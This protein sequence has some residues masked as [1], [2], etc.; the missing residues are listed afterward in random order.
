MSLFSL[1]S[2]QGFLD[3]GFLQCGNGALQGRCWMVWCFAKVTTSI[4]P[5]KV[6]AT[7]SNIYWGDFPLNFKHT[8]HLHTLKAVHCYA[9]LRFL[10]HI[11][12][13]W[14]ETKSWQLKEKR[15]IILHHIRWRL[16]VITFL[17]ILTHVL[18]N[19]LD[20]SLIVHVW[21]FDSLDMQTGCSKQ[22]ELL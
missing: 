13:H 7:H 15:C 8:G 19:Q 9:S 3:V 6:V 1:A 4:R 21:R 12:K 11:S 10:Y 17:H 2:L 22:I 5:P 18:W 16:T 14:K 20:K